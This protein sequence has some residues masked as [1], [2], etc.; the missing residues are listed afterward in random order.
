MEQVHVTDYHIGAQQKIADGIY[1]FWFE[2][3]SLRTRSPS[4]SEGGSR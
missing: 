3:E 4:E 1:K 2:A